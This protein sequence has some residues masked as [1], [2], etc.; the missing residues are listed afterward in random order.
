MASDD[1]GRVSRQTH[2]LHTRPKAAAGPHPPSAGGCSFLN[3]SAAAMLNSAAPSSPTP[4][5]DPRISC[6]SKIAC[7][8]G[9]KGQFW[10]EI[11]SFSKHER[12]WLKL[13]GRAIILTSPPGLVPSPSLVAIT[14]GPRVESILFFIYSIKK[15]NL[16]KNLTTI[17]ALPRTVAVW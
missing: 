13:R 11:C 9:K 4:L 8:C 1:S 3:N 14:T 7:S 12:S 5:P 16:F 15:A 10:T 6:G 17:A 2:H